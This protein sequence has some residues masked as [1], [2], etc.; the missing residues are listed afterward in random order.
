MGMRNSKGYKCGKL[1]GFK[2][3]WWEGVLTALP[4]LGGVLENIR[5]LNED[6]NSKTW[7]PEMPIENPE[8]VKAYN[9][10]MS[11][12]ISPTQYLNMS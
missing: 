12:M 6:R 2:K 1:P 8:A 5:Q 7:V 9:Q 3:G 11:D 10:I 4:H